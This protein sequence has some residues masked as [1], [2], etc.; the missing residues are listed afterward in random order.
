MFSS[1]MQGIYTYI[2]E[3]NHVPR[4]YI[5]AANLSLLFMVPISPVP[6]FALLYF[7][8]STFRSMCAMPSMAVFCSSLTLWFPDMLLTYYYYYYYYYY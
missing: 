3:T 4:E 7:Y 6:A 8:V 2:P 5:V 1:V